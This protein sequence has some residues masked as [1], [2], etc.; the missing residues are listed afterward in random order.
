MRCPRSQEHRFGEEE[1]A[2][3]IQ[4]SAQDKYKENQEPTTVFSNEEVIGDLGKNS[5]DGAK[6]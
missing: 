3:G 5:F 1:R 6:G 4:G 2:A